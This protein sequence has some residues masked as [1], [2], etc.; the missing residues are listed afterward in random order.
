MHKKYDLIK[1]LEE[2]REDKQTY[3]DKKKLFQDE[4]R[5]MMLAKLKKRKGYD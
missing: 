2:I 3:L 5:K 1:M 4:I